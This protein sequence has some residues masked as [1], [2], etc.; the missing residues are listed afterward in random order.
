MVF[1]DM[2]R[3]MP[4]GS[5][6]LLKSRKRPHKDQAQQLWRDLVKAAVS[7]LNRSGALLLKPEIVPKRN[8]SKRLRIASRD[9]YQSIGRGQHW[10]PGGNQK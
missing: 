7:S 4:D 2:G 8:R 9:R 5:P 10:L 6:A 3:A 1:V